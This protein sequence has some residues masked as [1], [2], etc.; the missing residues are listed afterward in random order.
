MYLIK[1][2]KF[3]MVTLGSKISPLEEDTQ[4]VAF[5]MKDG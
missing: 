1:K 4:F 2:L 3:C 5:D